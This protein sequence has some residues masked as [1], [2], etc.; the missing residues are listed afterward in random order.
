MPSELFSHRA[1]RA[2]GR[3]CRLAA[4]AGVASL[5]LAPAHAWAQAFPAVTPL[6]QLLDP[7]N[8][9]APAGVII[10]GADAGD[11]SGIAVAGVGD[12]S[13]DG[14][15]DLAIGARDADFGQNRDRPGEVYVIYGRGPAQPL[16]PPTLR[17]AS[18]AAATGFRVAGRGGFAGTGGALGAAGD[19]NGDGLPDMLIGTP[20]A[21]TPD[22]L[23]G[24]ASVVFGRAA[25]QPAFPQTFDLFTIDGQNGFIL[26]NIFPDERV[27][28]A[29]AA[30]DINGDGLDDLVLGAPFASPQGRTFAGAVY[31]IFGSATPFPPEFNLSAL[32]GSNGFRVEGVSVGD[33][34]GAAVT[35]AG[36]LNADGIDDLV[37]GAPQA[38]AGGPFLAGATFVLFGR[39]GPYDAAIGLGGLDGQRGLVIQGATSEDGSGAAVAFAG[40]LNNDG[41]DDLA[42]GA[43]TANPAGRFDAGTASVIFGRRTPFPAALRTDTPGAGFTLASHRSNA[44]LGHAVAPAGDFNGD[45]VDDLLVGAPGA[46]PAGTTYVVF[47][48]TTAL[49]PFPATIP[50]DTANGV[51]AA[52]FNG[53]DADD[54]SGGSVARVGDANGDG[55]DDI[56]IGALAADPGG[57]NRAGESYLIFGRVAPPCPADFN[58]DTLPADIFDL[59]DFLAALDTG[60]DYNNDGSPA[61]IFDLFDFLAVLDQGCP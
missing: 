52:A 9:A 21:S 13:G 39:P 3:S 45:G 31:V 55:V 43:P 12:I 5:A 44:T 54:F 23:T 35:A 11:V 33:R 61:D 26:N 59:F 40:D 6:A 56:L 49:A 25:P 28:S 57:R 50:T 30:G 22:P 58:A 46:D 29:V 51:N 8:T 14:R 27:G 1:Q 15:P 37:M 42:V 17:L 20:T 16:F 2:T 53:I 10:E 47:G 34:L 48:R 32:D 38:S 41:I 18:L 60:L 19:M 7:A 4:A 24:G 36:D